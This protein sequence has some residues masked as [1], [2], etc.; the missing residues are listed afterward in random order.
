MEPCSFFYIFKSKESEAPYLSEPASCE[1]N[2]DDNN[3]SLRSNTEREALN[4]DRSER[5]DSAPG[6]HWYGENL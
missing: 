5:T 4:R 1:D 6:P 2:N 3:N